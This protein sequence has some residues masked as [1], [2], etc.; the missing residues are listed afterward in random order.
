MGRGLLGIE[1]CHAT[2]RRRLFRPILRLCRVVGG[3]HKDITFVTSSVKAVWCTRVP[4]DIVATGSVAGEVC[5]VSSSALCCRSG[6]KAITKH[7][8]LPCISL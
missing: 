2:A 6:T 5:E 8:C 3:V 4:S 1:C 7:M